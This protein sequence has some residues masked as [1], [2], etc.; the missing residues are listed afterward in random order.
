MDFVS[1]MP[2]K[3]PQHV[4]LYEKFIIPPV[5]LLRQSNSPV[6]VGCCFPQAQSNYK[7]MWV[8]KCSTPE[9]NIKPI[10]CTTVSPE[11]KEFALTKERQAIERLC[12]PLRRKEKAQT[13]K[14][15]AHHL[16]LKA[17]GHSPIESSQ[18]LLH[19]GLKPFTCQRHTPCRGCRA[20]C[21]SSKGRLDQGAG[22]F[23]SCSLRCR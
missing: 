15:L 21:A 5:K 8:L 3:A 16:L 11:N 12:L 19:K 7:P 13:Q 4:P 2:L 17:L 14:L 23:D 9:D 10:F 20:T 6:Y 18:L 1:L 22:H